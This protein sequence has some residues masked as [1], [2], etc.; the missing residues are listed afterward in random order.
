MADAR[1]LDTRPQDAPLREDVRNLGALVGAMLAEQLGAAFLDTV[2]AV[3]TAAIRR[4]EAGLPADDLAARLAGLAPTQAEALTRAFST[5]FHTVNVAER[6][7]RIRRRRAYQRAGARPQPD[8]LHDV[9]ER[10]RA[11]GVGADA[12]HALLARMRIEPVFTAHPTEAVRR[13]LL[14]KEQ[15]IVRCL[16]SDLDGELTP[17]ERTAARAQIRTALSVAWQT[18]EASVLRPSVQDE[19][20]HIGFYLSEVL[21]RVLPVFYELLED[22]LGTRF[23][24]AQTPP[25]LLR[26]GTWVGGDM[27]GNPNVDA[28]TIAATLETQ[29]ALV[30]ER[31]L[32]ETGKLARLLSQSRSRVVV[33]AAV[34][35]RSADYARLLPQAAA[36]IRP[37]HA[38]MPYRVLLSLIQARLRATLDGCAQAYAS[39]DAFCDDIALILCSLQAHGGAHAGAFAV[40]RLLWRARSFGFHLA[41]LDVRQDARVHAHA[42]AAALGDAQWNE[43]DEQSQIARLR[44]AAAGTAVLPA[45]A[46]DAGR[47]LDAVFAAL[48]AARAAHGAAGVGL[49]IISMAHGVADVLAVLALARRGALEVEGSVPLDIAPLLETID[50]LHHGPAMLAELLAEPGY[51]AHLAMRGDVQTVMLGYSD[52]AKDGGILAS[53]WAL[54]RAQQALLAVAREAGVR[55]T[56]FHGRGGSVSRGG[57][58]T[59][60]AILAAPRG[61]VD[62]RLRFT[63]QGEVVHRNYGIRALALRTLEQLSGAV[64]AASLDGRPEDPRAPQWQA[65]MDAVA[66]A[67]ERAYRE[68]IEAER[69]VDYFRLATPIDV[70]ERMTLSSRPPRRGAAGGGLEGLRAIPWVFA[71][72]QSRAGLTA[73]YGVGT[74]LAGAARVHGEQQLREMARA[75]P[76]LSTLLDDVEMVLAKCDL[77]IAERFSQLAGAALHQRFFPRLRAE[78]EATQH[79]V[80]RLKGSDALLAGDPRLAQSIRLRN[81]YIDP[82]SLMQLD[83]LARW[84]A[85]DRQD[86]ALLSALVATVNGIAQGLQNTG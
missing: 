77:D 20:D 29:R 18:A 44:T 65:A 19:V 45:A 1:E 23:D 34:L 3:R 85:G 28:G 76:F 68:L 81:P 59:T 71:W 64:L 54:Q 61:S 38:D 56:F 70:I 63:E 57:G 82:M 79:W 83:L 55:L 17:G 75:W 67:G 42:I 25:A 46:D 48:A 86:A 12:L 9:I 52:S 14:E 4:R 49:Y 58:K 47:A 32:A 36:G 37:R 60:R 5:Y 74:A 22:A 7:H 39:A 62:G 11:S 73:W 51:R 69:F 41:R 27:D 21:Y 31:Y 33:D 78:F 26:F 15:V 72:T 53:R 30:I 80:L 43:R 2:E 50:D 10:L 66:G 24:D 16:V 40:R 6:V 35:A 13:S 84:R 8:G